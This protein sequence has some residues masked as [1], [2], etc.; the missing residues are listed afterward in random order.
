MV[1][2]AC[3]SCRPGRSACIRRWSSSL[4]ITQRVSSRLRAR[5]TRL[6]ITI[7]LCGPSRRAMSAGVTRKSWMFMGVATSGGGKGCQ[8]FAGGLDFIAHAGGLLEILL[9]DGFGEFLFE[10]FDAIGEFA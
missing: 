9:G 3:L 7:L 8:F 5:R 2:Q 6:D 4:I 10:R 1:C